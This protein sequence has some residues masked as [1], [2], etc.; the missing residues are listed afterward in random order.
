MPMRIAH[1]TDFST[2]SA[3]AYKHA[4]ALALSARGRLD[5]L[6]VR[7]PGSAHEWQS[8]PHVRETLGRWGLLSA[9]DGPQH[10][11][12]KLGLRIAKVEIDHADPGAGLSQFFL[13]HRPDLLVLSAHGLDGIDRWVHASVSEDVIRRTHIPTLLLGP[14]AR[15]LVAPDTGRVRL[16]RVLMPVVSEPAPAQALHLMEDLFMRLG[17]RDVAVHLMQVV[18]PGQAPLEDLLDARGTTRPVAHYAGDNIIESILAVA[19]N[20]EA[21]VIAMPTFTHRGIAHALRGSTTSHVVARATCPVL[22]LPMV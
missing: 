16:A 9:H 14:H 4:L 18:G 15:C 21:D 13:G 20:W 8:F 11:E 5:I 7:P 2:H 3:V 1:T 6:H 19:E 12:G 22:T 10:I 17:L